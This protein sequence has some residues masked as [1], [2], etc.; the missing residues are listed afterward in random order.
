MLVLLVLVRVTGCRL[1]GDRLTDGAAK[2]QLL[3][4][5]EKA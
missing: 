3:S 5:I 4:A 1:D 2:E